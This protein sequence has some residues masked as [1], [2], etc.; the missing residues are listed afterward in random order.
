[1][2]MTPCVGTQP[3]TS[4]RFSGREDEPMPFLT[5]SMTFFCVSSVAVEPNNPARSVKTGAGAETPPAI[6]TGTRPWPLAKMVWRMDSGLIVAS[7]TTKRRK[8]VSGDGEDTICSG[9]NS[10]VEMPAEATTDTGGLML[11]VGL[12]KIAGPGTGVGLGNS[13]RGNTDCGNGRASCASP[14]AA[15]MANKARMR[16]KGGILRNR[17]SSFTTPVNERQSQKSPDLHQEPSPA[18]GS[19]TTRSTLCLVMMFPCESRFLMA[20]ELKGNLIWRFRR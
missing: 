8:R 3:T 12:M 20:M 17:G 6:V 18:F 10:A 2:A 19:R 11:L 1:M 13:A 15:D 9:G 5:V 7:T 16:K 4:T 14:E